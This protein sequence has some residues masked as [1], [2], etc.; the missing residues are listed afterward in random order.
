MVNLVRLN[1]EDRVH[2]VLPSGWQD[3]A[4]FIEYP[5]LAISTIVAADNCGGNHGGPI[6]PT[7]PT[8]PPDTSIS[9]S[10]QLQTFPDNQNAVFNAD[11]N[12]TNAAD[13]TNADIEIKNGLLNIKPEHKI[14]AGG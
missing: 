1:L 9:L 7:D 11:A 4:Q 8:Q 12:F 13:G 2:R 10:Q 14:K 6:S 3:L 5:L